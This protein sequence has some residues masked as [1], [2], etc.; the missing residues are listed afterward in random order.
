[1]YNKSLVAFVDLLGFSNDV[2]SKSFD[3]VYKVLDQFYDNIVNFDNFHFQILKDS[4]ENIYQEWKFKMDKNH[5]EL[6]LFSD[7]VV[8][9]YPVSE[10]PIMSGGPLDLL[11]SAF[12]ELQIELFERGIVSRGGLTIGDLYIDKDKVFGPALVQ[13][14]DLEK[15]ACYPIIVIDQ[16]VIKWSGLAMQDLESNGLAFDQL[17]GLHY[18]DVVQQMNWEIKWI[19][20]HPSNLHALKGVKMVRVKQRVDAISTVLKVGLKHK[21][22]KV[23]MKYHWLAAKFLSM[24]KLSNV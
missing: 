18:I 10:I 21:E 19:N 5:A 3:D 7:C 14:V 17:I 13:A 11:M 20:D 2:E 4:Y 12:G 8:W 9:S 16:S 1:M 6:R 15:R 24:E 23:R 22:E